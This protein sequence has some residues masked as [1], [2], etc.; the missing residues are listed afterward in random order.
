MKSDL[1]KGPPQNI[2]ISME[3]LLK[4]VEYWNEK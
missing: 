2:E 3:A 4:G 1:Y